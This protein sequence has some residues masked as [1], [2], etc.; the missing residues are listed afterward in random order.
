[1]DWRGTVRIKLGFQ[2]Q[3]TYK[4]FCKLIKNTAPF[5]ILLSLLRHKKA[6]IKRGLDHE[7]K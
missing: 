1:M 5:R 4:H 7:A 2:K 3:V 6:K